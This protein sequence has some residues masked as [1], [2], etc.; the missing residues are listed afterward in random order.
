MKHQITITVDDKGK[1][2]ISGPLQ[3]KILMLGLL[4]LAKD[5]VLN[6]KPEIQIPKSSVL[7]IRRIPQ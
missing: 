3:D 2:N 5:A 1:L 7:D 4:E 6:F